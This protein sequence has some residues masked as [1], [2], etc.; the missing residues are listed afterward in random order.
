[1]KLFSALAAIP[2]A[3]LLLT[4]LSLQSLDTNAELFDRVLGEMDRFS[5][6]EAS[7]HRDV[8]NAHAGMLRNYDP[9]VREV[10]GLEKSLARLQEATPVDA[11]AAILIEHL[12]TSLTRQEDLVEQF[13]SNNALLQNSLAYFGVFTGFFGHSST[14][15]GA[16]E[17]T[18]SALATAMLRL[19][20][21]T[22]PANVRDVQDRLDELAI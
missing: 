9:L 10:T 22:L 15:T 18:V 5:M 2:L 7:L 13:K 20:L 6:L 14:I 19:T 17:T 21:D 16:V 3:V 8:L 1:M 11:E 4:W 12:V